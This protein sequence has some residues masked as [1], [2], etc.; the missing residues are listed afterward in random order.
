MKVAF[1]DTH[2]FEQEIF[3]KLNNGFHHDLVF[4]EPRLKKD[5]ALLARGHDVVCSFAN[6]KVDRDTIEILSQQGIRLIALRCA[7]FNHVDVAAARD[8]GISV[9]RVPE[10]SPYAVAEHVLALVQSLNRKTHRAYQRVRELNFSLDGLVGFDLNGKTI[11]IVGAGRIGSVVA[12]IFHGFGCKILAHDIEA[13]PQLTQRYQ[14]EYVPLQYLL[15]NSQIISLH[16]PLSKSTF[17]MIGEQEINLM[18]EG[19]MIINTGRGALID[20]KA[21]IKGLKSGRIGSAGLD[22]YEEEEGVFFH[23]LSDHVLKDDVLARLLTFPNVLITSHQGFLTTEAL[24][25][26]A[27][28]TLKN[29]F[30]FD[31]GKILLNQVH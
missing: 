17:H 5:T 28:T 18:R 27:E 7:G 2:H 25:N 26:I 23:D 9:V 8:F 12:K 6:D 22:V 1:F 16:A 31:Q 30:D 19:V 14:V 15:Q 24:H 3:Q 13:N 20:T 11:G 21:L 10:Y 4:L 29:I